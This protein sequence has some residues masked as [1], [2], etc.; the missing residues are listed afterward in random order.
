[1]FPLFGK[2][3]KSPTEVVR[4]LKDHLATLEKGG[5]GKKQ[6]KAQEEVSKQLVNI[7]SLLFGSDSEQQSDVVLAQLSQEMYN[8]GLLLLLLRNLHRI[9]FEGKKDA[10]QIFNNV[11]RRQI[12]TRTPTV[13]YICTTPEILFTLCR[14]YEQQEI[15]LNCGTMLRE[16]LKYEALSKIVLHS[17]H[18]F[19]FFKYV[20]VSTFDIASDAFATFKELLTRHKMLAADFLEA[21]YDGVFAQ[22]QRLLHSD[23]YV[24]K[25]QSLKLLGELLLDRHNFSVMTKYISNPDNLKLMMNMLKEKS[26][27]IQFEA[28]HV[29]KVF[30]ANPNKPK[31][32]LDI[33]LRNQ[34]KLVD[35][36]SKFHTDRSEDEQFNDEKAYLIKQIK[37][38]KP[39]PEDGAP[40]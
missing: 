21:N 7:T 6:E 16:C 19:M 1:M 31:P 20:E 14:G 26:R 23:N 10:A 27:N 13:E 2:S 28:F 11:L 36:L 25:R 33:L 22:Y 35:F 32:I 34:D 30:V 40:Q 8:S 3:S 29:F 17:D 37:E 24:T 15:A 38:L 18:F 12:G 4:Q 9:D 5:D 39:L